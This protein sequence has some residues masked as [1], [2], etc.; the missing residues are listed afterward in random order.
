MSPLLRPATV[1]LAALGAT[2]ALEDGVPQ[3]SSRRDLQAAASSSADSGVATAFVVASATVSVAGMIASLVGG[4]GGGGGDSPW[5]PPEG[6]WDKYPSA[7]TGMYA[8]THSNPDICRAPLK[9]RR[10]RVSQLD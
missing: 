10:S 5:E 9:D 4:G 7:M 2:C 3:P 1:L 6:H 8:C